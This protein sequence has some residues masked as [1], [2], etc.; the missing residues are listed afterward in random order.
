MRYHEPIG[1]L[2]SGEAYKWG[3]IQTNGG[4]EHLALVSAAERGM[5]PYLPRFVDRV[6]CSRRHRERTKP[7]LRPLFVGYVFVGFRGEEWR[8]LF[9]SPGVADV[10]HSG[11][12]PR[13]V[14]YRLLALMA[15][16]EEAMSGRFKTI[17][18]DWPFKPGDTV[19]LV[20]GPFMGFYAKLISLDDDGRIRLLLDILGG[21]TEISGLT[22]AMIEAA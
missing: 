6:R 9:R 11:D 17:R 16:H 10:L 20:D 13:L 22:A 4:Q 3:C 21:A 18:H 15:G 14:P 19:R 1:G 7:V 12:T 8:E 2:A 5:R